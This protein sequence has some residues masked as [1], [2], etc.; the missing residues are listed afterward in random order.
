MNRK[1][2]KRKDYIISI[3]TLIFMLITGIFM[4]YNFIINLVFLF[5]TIVLGIGIGAIFG[6]L[7]VK[8]LKQWD[9]LS[10]EEYEQLGKDLKTKFSLKKPL[11]IIC[12]SLLGIATLG[13]VIGKGIASNV[14]QYGDYSTQ[15]LFYC[16]VGFLGVIFAVVFVFLVVYG[17]KTNKVSD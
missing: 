6:A 16:I 17:L 13:A 2:P 7:I 1:Y 8:K 5:A 9:E 4:L 12:G 15:K 11:G 14:R 10:D 3:C